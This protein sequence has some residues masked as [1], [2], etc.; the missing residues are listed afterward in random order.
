[1]ARGP[2]CRQQRR[3][4]S[5]TEFS[6]SLLPARAD[7]CLR[8]ASAS[9]RAVPDERK[10]CCSCWPV[11]FLFLFL[12]GQSERE[13]GISRV[14]SLTGGAVWR[15][16]R[17]LRCSMKEARIKGAEFVGGAAWKFWCSNGIFI[18]FVLR[19]FRIGEKCFALDSHVW[20]MVV[21]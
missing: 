16:K 9:F 21:L 2:S 18:Y 15:W 10:T 4:A 8:R 20:A 14:E 1:M 5:Y 11:S 3:A 12:S 6:P 7:A 19:S 13:L 17:L